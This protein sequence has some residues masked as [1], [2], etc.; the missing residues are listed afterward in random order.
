MVGEQ[1]PARRRSVSPVILWLAAAELV[2][3]VG[4]LVL[5]GETNPLYYLLIVAVAAVVVL[6]VAS[7]DRRRTKAA[8]SRAAAVDPGATNPDTAVAGGLGAEVSADG[9]DEAA[10]VE[11]ET[12]VAG[13]HDEPADEPVLDL[14]APAVAAMAPAEPVATA[15][16]A[17]AEPTTAHPAPA[18]R[19][20]SGKAA[21]G[22]VALRSAS[23]EF[24]AALIGYGMR[25]GVR[26]ITRADRD[27][28]T[29]ALRVEYDLLLAASCC[30]ENERHVV[31]ELTTWDSVSVLHLLDTGAEQ[32]SGIARSVVAPYGRLPAAT[33][34]PVRRDP[35]RV[36]C[37]VATLALDPRVANEDALHLLWRGIYDHA[38]RGGASDVVWTLA[39]DLAVLWRD[40]YGFP[41]S[42]L[43]DGKRAPSGT[44]VTIA[45]SLADLEQKLLRERPAYYGWMTV[46][47]SD[48]E[49]TALGLPVDLSGAYERVCGHVMAT[50]DAVRS[51]L[52]LQ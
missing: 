17:T 38:R 47:F 37:E 33:R 25:V 10:A 52:V 45:I 15:E 5:M 26:T 22:G 43:G 51:P 8:A 21:A 36:S 39:I 24:V 18:A 11:I 34:V 4:A 3:G 20:A 23:E 46:A 14:T 13:G 1:G 40:Q 35:S 27:G 32:G 7:D 42:F 9:S 28:W 6:V 16:P 12:T 50:L 29:G 44:A 49:R 30:A 41:I 2:V 31:G 48:A 19:P